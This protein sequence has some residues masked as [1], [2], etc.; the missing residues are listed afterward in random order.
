M[1]K[2]MSFDKK[3]KWDLHT[4]YRIYMEDNVKMIKFIGMTDRGDAGKN[5]LS[6]FC[7]F[8]D[9]RCK[10]PLEEFLLWDVYYQKD[11]LFKNSNNI[12]TEVS[13]LECYNQVNEWVKG[14]GNG[15]LF[16]KLFDL[17]E[18]TLCGYYYGY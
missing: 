15:S 18:N 14:D 11:T 3:E 10:M 2:K 17:T 12:E 8:C 13:P 5:Y 1:M 4:F 7:V 9:E 16:K 6:W